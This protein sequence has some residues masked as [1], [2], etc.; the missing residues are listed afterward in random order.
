M[1]TTAPLEAQLAGCGRRIIAK[2]LTWGTSGNV[3]VRAPDDGFLI[4]ASG[5]ALDAL[6][7][8]TIVRCPLVGAASSGSAAPSVESGMHRRVYAARD[9]VGAVIHASPFHAT[10]VAASSLALDPY[11]TTDTAYYVRAVARVPPLRPGSAALAEAVSAAIAEVDCLILD[12]HGCL[13]AGAGLEEALVR[14]EAL[15]LLCRMLV[16]ESLGFPLRRMT[17]AEVAAC[18]SGDSHEAA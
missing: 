17:A 2:D 10:L 12:Q 11:V 4:S 6:A 7:V 18:M 5:V 15:E 16:L 3:S 1:M 8:G 9:D 13:V 14:L